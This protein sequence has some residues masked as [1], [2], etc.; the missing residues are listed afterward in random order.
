[1]IFSVKAFFRK[2]TS[3]GAF[4]GLVVVPGVTFAQTGVAPSQT[5]LFFDD[6]RN[7][8]SNFR[9]PSQDQSATRSSGVYDFSEDGG[10]EDERPLGQRTYAGEESGRQIGVSAYGATS[11][12]AGDYT[13]A[14]GPYPTT[15][16]YFAPTYITDPFLSGKRNVK[17]GPVNIGLGMNANVEY[18]DNVTRRNT[19]KLDD[20]IAGVMMNVDMNWQ[21]TENNRLS[22]SVGFGVDH[23]F[24]HPEASPNGN[25]LV[26]N[27]LPGSTIAFDVKVGDIVF[28]LYDRVSVRPVAQNDFGLD[29]NDV[30]GTVQNDV[31][32]AMNWALNSKTNLSLNFN[33]SD[34]WALEDAYSNYDRVIHTVAGSLAWS[35]TGT[36][37]VGIEGS[38]SWIDYDSEFNND[39]TTASAGVFVIV[40]ITQ[41]TILKASGGYQQFD[42]DSPPVFTRQVSEADIIMAQKQ[43]DGV[44]QLYG[45]LFTIEDPMELERRTA[46][47]DA[48]RMELE[49]FIAFQR[50][51]KQRD[52]ELENSRTYDNEDLSDYYYNVT[53][54]NQI[55]SRVSH[56]LSFGHES[57]INNT[58]NFITADFISYGV[59][60]IAWK[61]AQ[62]A[63]STY[64]EDAE[65]SGGRLAEDTTQ[66]GFDA[67]LGQ[68]LT[69]RIMVGLGYHYGDTDSNLE[70]RDYQQHSFTVDFNYSLSSKLNMGLGYR[71][72]TTE[73]EDSQLSFDQ[74]RVIM[75]MNYNF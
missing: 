35:P 28:V 66:W 29:Q 72:W 18:N 68:R 31:G 30:F 37:T 54:F 50:L 49:N 47:L 21:I 58:S 10:Y 71:Y 44:N 9:T 53:L 23:Y 19:N 38:F 46:E 69:K 15:S 24:N 4:M 57:S 7:R 16:T 42:F 22:V 8:A 25:D 74:N 65:E 13:G 64:L 70:M 17:L 52:D 48:A 45:Q 20:I 26:L 41:K 55:N 1:M 62:I 61:G 51:Q 40:P 33:R 2:F 3:A 43:L 39:G 36:Y 12:T 34:S 11:R 5:G 63:L 60:I 73:A 14:T 32:L 59:G 27:V 6:L 75:S 56:Q 67:F